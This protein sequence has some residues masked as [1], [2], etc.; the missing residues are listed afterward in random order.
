MYEKK[1]RELTTRKVDTDVAEKRLKKLR[2]IAVGTYNENLIENRITE[3]QLKNARRHL[4]SSLNTA[5]D[6][7]EDE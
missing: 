3:F 2:H 6:D 4:F 7:H 5:L 1:R